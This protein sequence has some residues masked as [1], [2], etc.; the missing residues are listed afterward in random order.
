MYVVVDCSTRPQ[1]TVL[2]R[3]KTEDEAAEFIET[4]PEYL[5]GR[6]GLDGPADDYTN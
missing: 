4:L 1:A 2:G 5:T 6:Y 3:F